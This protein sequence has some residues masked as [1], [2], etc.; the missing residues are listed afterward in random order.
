MCPSTHSASEV[1]TFWGRGDIVAGPQYAKDLCEH[2]DMALGS[3]LLHFWTG[4]GM[5]VE[6]LAKIEM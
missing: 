2:Q 3:G 1:R 6:V 4:G 5:S